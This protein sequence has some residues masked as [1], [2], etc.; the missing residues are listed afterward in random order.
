MLHPLFPMARKGAIWY[1]GCSDVNRP[2]LYE[3]LFRALVADWRGHF[4]H[5]DGF[6]IFLVQLASIDAAASK[7]PGM[8]F[9][10]IMES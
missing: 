8:G 1:Q 2:D 5:P 4:T 6:P 7:S 9:A 3:K 10:S